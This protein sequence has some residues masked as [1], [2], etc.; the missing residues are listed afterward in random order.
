MFSDSRILVNQVNR[1]WNSSGHLSEYC[2]T[3]RNALAEFAGWQMSWIPR[4]WNERAD[5]RV[6][7]AFA[8]AGGGVTDAGFG[9]GA[10]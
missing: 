8:S 10:M 6:Q 4:E 2:E 1:L 9:A 3:A 7:A 5:Q